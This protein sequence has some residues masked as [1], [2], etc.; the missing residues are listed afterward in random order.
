MLFYRKVLPSGCNEDKF[1]GQ[2]AKNAF[3]TSNNFYF[4]A[5][6]HTRF[7]HAFTACRCVFNEVTLVGSKQRN[8]LENATTWSKRTLKT[9]VATR[10]YILGKPTFPGRASQLVSQVRVQFQGNP[11]F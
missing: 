10:L 7:Q 11:A 4:K 1:M 2:T 5:R 8:Y 6:C 9:C 3:I